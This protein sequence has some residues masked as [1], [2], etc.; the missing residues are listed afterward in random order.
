MLFF[1]DLV[2]HIT[3]AADALGNACDVQGND[4]VKSERNVSRD[5]STRVVPPSRQPEALLF[6]RTRFLL[7]DKAL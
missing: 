1:D 2:L 3:P 7:D 5:L 4:K 6:Q